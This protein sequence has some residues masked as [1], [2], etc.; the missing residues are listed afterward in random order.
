MKSARNS[1]NNPKRNLKPLEFMHPIQGHG[2]RGEL[3]SAGKA[4]TLQSRRRSRQF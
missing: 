2:S 1:D 3:C 4:E